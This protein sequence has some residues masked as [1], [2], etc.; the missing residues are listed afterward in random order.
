VNRK[1][2][3]AAMQL[4]VLAPLASA[5]VLEPDDYPSGTDLSNVF[6]GVTLSTVNSDYGD[7]RVFALQPTEPYWASTGQLVFGHVDPYP[8]H[9]VMDT[10]SP[11][12]Y[13]ALRAHFSPA[14]T[15]F[16]VDII[17]ND[18]LDYGQLSAFDAAGN[19]LLSLE[20]GPLAAGDIETLTVSGVG[21]IAYIYAGGRLTD[22]V[23]L[24]N[25]Y[26]ELAPEPATA[27][28]GALGLV[29]LRRR[30]TS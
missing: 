17:G 11:F 15:L 2:L 13:G 10:Y 24:D 9:W 1:L 28:L 20:T 19:L 27:L 26:V 5:E 6:P 22:T 7:A 12:R 3:Q 16:R 25:M 4:M 14:A 29:V 30:E 23:C 8:V 18:S 21:D